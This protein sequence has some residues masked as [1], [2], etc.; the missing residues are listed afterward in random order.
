[1]KMKKSTSIRFVLAGMLLVASFASNSGPFDE[2]TLPFDYLFLGGC[3]TITKVDVV[4]DQ[5]PIFSDR[6]PE[7]GN[8]GSGSDITQIAA[9]I[10][11]VGSLV[12]AIFGTVTAAVVNS[13]FTETVKDRDTKAAS[14][15]Y[16]NVYRINIK[17]DFGVDYE[18]IFEMIH[19]SDIEVGA[20]LVVAANTK[21]GYNAIKRGF[22]K[23][24][25]PHK[26]P[27]FDKNNL[28]E[29]YFVVCYGSGKYGYGQLIPVEN[30][31]FDWVEVSS[32]VKA[33]IESQ[34][35]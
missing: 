20:R 4:T 30:G 18:S 2:S 22:L 29:D 27:A 7:E 24:R 23:N 11:G 28:P 5:T 12:A 32:E 10:P 35:K 26:L 3:G 34:K 1:M 17:S 15:G 6:R 25:W 19:Q 13:S 9:N 21:N 31:G 8:I 14:Q 33:L 16:K